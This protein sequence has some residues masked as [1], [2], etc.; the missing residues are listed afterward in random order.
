ME[1]VPLPQLG[2]STGPAV[3]EA[4]SGTGSAVTGAIYFG[5]PQGQTGVLGA[6]GQALPLIALVGVAWF[7][8][9]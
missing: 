6:V 1:P 2:L 3:S 9:R 7:L 5:S 8:T 4:T